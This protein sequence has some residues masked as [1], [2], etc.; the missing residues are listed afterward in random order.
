[1]QQVLGLSD[2]GFR[3]PIMKKCL[4][5]YLQIGLKQIKTVS[6]RKSKVKNNQIDILE[7]KNTITPNLKIQWVRS[8]AQQ[9]G[10]GKKEAMNLKIEQ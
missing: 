8:T 2:K 5:E 7:L 9:K 4:H 10:G 1:M 3:G 6:G